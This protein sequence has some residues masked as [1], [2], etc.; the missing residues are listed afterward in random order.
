[1]NLKISLGAAIAIMLMVA[2]GVFS[3]TMVYA[4]YSYNQRS[5]DL[6]RRQAMY[7]K[8]SEVDRTVRNNFGGTINE[9][10]LMD[11]VVRGYI[12]G[13]GDR[14]SAYISA[15]EVKRASGSNEG[16]DLGIGAALEISAGGY[17]AVTEVYPDSPAQNAGIAV[18]DLIIKIDETDLTPENAAAMLAGIQGEAGTRLSLTVRKGSEDIVIPDLTRRAVAIPSVYSRVASSENIGYISI[19]QFN[20]NAPDQFARELRR[21]L[22][23]GVD[24][25]IFD[26]RD[27]PG[28]SYEA[29][30]R[31]LDRLVPDGALY[32]ATY[33]DG[34]VKI[35]GI[36]DANETEL[37]MT[38]I[39]NAG[40]LEA[41]ELFAQ[42]LKDFGKAEIV[43]ASTGG[44]GVL[45][46]RLKLS[47]GSAIDLTVAVINTASGYVYNGAGVKPDFDVP[48][49]EPWADLD[50][51]TDAQL[52]KAL[53]VVTAKLRA[54]QTAQAE[55]EAPP[56]SP[57]PQVEQPTATE[58]EAEPPA[59]PAETEPAGSTNG[60]KAPE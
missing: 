40:T 18:D 25:L 31:I 9:N 46:D 41:A 21:V 55:S 19:R 17:L 34:T 24:S 4:E 50:E 44:K 22:A 2:A 39:V 36:S 30:A 58:P 60:G 45:L 23:E 27:N 54:A 12:A 3:G 26:V 14:Y 16:E 32:S 13:L 59:T 10:V 38:V 7:A 43:G 42:D 48:M 1:M 8:Y 11:N 5:N 29:A 56:D 37:P 51:T 53:E 52:K 33:S 35:I 28:T 49:A 6:E 15:E 57:P 47:D 20:A